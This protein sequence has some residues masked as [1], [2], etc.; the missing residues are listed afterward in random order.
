MKN[1]SSLWFISILI[2][3]AF[4]LLFLYYPMDVAVP[5]LGHSKNTQESESPARL[6][7][8][9]HP[10]KIIDSSSADRSNLIALPPLHKSDEYFKL[11]IVNLFSPSIE[12]LLAQSRI[13]ERIVAT[14]DNFPR[15]HISERIRPIGKVGDD[16]LTDGQ[17]GIGTY[18]ISAD[19]Y[20]RYDA[21]I[22]LASSVDMEKVVEVYRRYYPL[23][24]NAYMDLGY[25]DDYFNDRLVDVIAHLM[26]TP[27]VK[28]PVLLVRPNVLYEYR[29]PALAALS[30][31]QKLMVRMGSAHAA[32][33]KIKLRELHRLITTVSGT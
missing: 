23:F 32:Q 1:K 2:V 17:D 33:I 27:D 5:D 25:P 16:F 14:V 28:D 30:S 4:A 24:Q 21:I 15:I 9:L 6:P 19:N 20:K 31:G 26:A 13:I 12:N 3:A 18:S 10:I 7:R 11:E 8:P 29:D 22:A